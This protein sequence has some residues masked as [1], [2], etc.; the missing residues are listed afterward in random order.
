MAAD[1]RLRTWSPSKLRPRSRRVAAQGQTVGLPNR[2]P[3]S[4]LT[5]K[6][7]LSRQKFSLREAAVCFIQADFFSLMSDGG[8][9][10]NR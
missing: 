9:L 7:R 8:V 6:V 2:I 4:A 5:A 3:Q 10:Q 1:R